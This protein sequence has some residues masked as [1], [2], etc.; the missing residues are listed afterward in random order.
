[1]KSPFREI[2]CILPTVTKKPDKTDA[3]RDSSKAE[4]ANLPFRNGGE[5]ARHLYQ[6]PRGQCVHQPLDNQEE[7][8][9]RQEI[10]HAPINLQALREP[11]AQVLPKAAADYRRRY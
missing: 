9:S 1:M 7:C 10:L 6:K 8:K 5:N 4:G 2:P 3:Q 11:Q